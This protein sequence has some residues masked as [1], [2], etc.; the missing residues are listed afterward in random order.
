M[1]EKKIKK[2]K[3]VTIDALVGMVKK[4]FDHMDE[5]FNQHDKRFETIEKK[6]DDLEQGQEEIKLKLGD[7]AYRFELVELERRVNILERKANKR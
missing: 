3:V 7:V 5:R 2:T 6:M 1:S 4:G